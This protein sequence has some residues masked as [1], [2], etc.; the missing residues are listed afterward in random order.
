MSNTNE[1]YAVEYEAETAWA[2]NVSTFAT[3]RIAILGP[4]DTTK[5]TQDAVDPERAVQQL[6]GGTQPILGPKKGSFTMRVWA[7]GHGAATSGAVTLDP[8]EIFKGYF[9]GNPSL[10]E[11]QSCPTRSAASGTTA[12]AGSTTTAVNT[13][14][15]GTFARGS[16]C[17]LGTGG[18]SSD[19]RGGG[20]FYA[21]NNHTATVLTLRHATQ[22]ALNAADVIHS[23]VNFYFNETV[24]NTAVKGLRFRFLSADKKYICRGCWPM[25]AKLTGTNPGER[26]VWEIEWGVSSWDS[27]VTG[28]FPSAVASNQYNPAPIGGGELQVQD[29]GVTTRNPRNARGFTLDIDLGIVPLEGHNGVDPYQTTIGAVRT[30]SKIRAS[31]IEASG[32]GHDTWE[33]KYLAGT[34]QS[35]TWSGSTAAGTAL[36]VHLQNFKIDKRPVQMNHNGVN[37][38]MVEGYA[39]A[40]TD[41]TTELSQAACVIAY[42]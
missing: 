35:I 9:F 19:A 1:L 8:M 39:C 32:E 13:V 31:W 37:S 38:V 40:G 28:T 16:L 33:T 30:P 3:H 18:V 2:E 42:A 4:I 25:S 26:P 11:V 14:A 24:A 20:K 5:L 12:A 15:S 29:F 36:G 23:A 21:V 6:Q 17:R 22:A 41:L 10:T 27:T 34:A 7:T